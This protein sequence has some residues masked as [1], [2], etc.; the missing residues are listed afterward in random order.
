MAGSYKQLM[1]T[2]SGTLAV[3]AGFYVDHIDARAVAVGSVQVDTVGAS[4]V[5]PLNGSASAPA[6]WSK[7]FS[8]DRQS[9]VGP[10]TI[11]FANLDVIVVGYGS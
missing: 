3:P 7:D 10:L 2:G 5:I 6:A 4:P 1:G 8:G 9:L 11:T